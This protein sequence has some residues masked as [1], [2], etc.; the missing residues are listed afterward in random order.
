MDK[1][2]NCPNCG[3]VITGTVCEY[4]GTRFEDDGIKIELD[5][6]SIYELIIQREKHN[7]IIADDILGN[8]TIWD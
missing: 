5:G 2:T 1:M 3:A 6:K 7:L 4:C 8:P